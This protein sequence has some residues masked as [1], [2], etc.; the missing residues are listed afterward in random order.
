MRPTA[1]SSGELLWVRGLAVVTNS[2]PERPQRS[3]DPAFGNSPIHVV[4]ADDHRDVR[5]NL[6]LSLESE[7]DVAVIAVAD[8]PST[9]IRQVNHHAPDVLLLDLR[10]PNGSSVTVIRRLRAQMPDTEIVVMTTEQSP[11]FARQALD[12]GATGYVHADDAHSE[13]PDAIRRASHRQEYI[14]PRVAAALDGLRRGVDRDTLSP[15][16]TDVLRLIAL[17]F[18]S[19]EISDQLHLSR[20]TVETHRSQIQRKLGLS[21]RWQ[22]VRYALDHSL[23]G[24]S[25]QSP[26][27]ST[28][29]PKALARYQ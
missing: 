20:R 21:K 16:E 27:H 2:H 19:L 14:S 18:T 26:G 7:K 6:W 24:D 13:L 5:R 9:A 15:R 29:A 3:A 25:R 11:V 23:I 22:L 4:L 28:S 17:G 8:D 10:T 1:L 12:A